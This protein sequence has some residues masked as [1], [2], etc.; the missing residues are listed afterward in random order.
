M[1]GFMMNTSITNPLIIGSVKEFL[2][3]TFS[4]T[5]KEMYEERA[6][7]MQYDGGL[8]QEEAESEAIRIV[9]K[10]SLEI[11]HATI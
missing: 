3:S 7:I 9:I 1:K 4:E 11:K 8:T 10:T 2:L 5:E 6:A